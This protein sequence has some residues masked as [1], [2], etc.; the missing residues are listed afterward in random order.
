MCINVG[1]VTMKSLIV[2]T[3]K[4]VNVS[5][6]ELNVC[7]FYSK[8]WK[9]IIY[10]HCMSQS[11]PFR[12]TPPISKTNIAPRHWDLIL[13]FSLTFYHLHLR[14]SEW[15]YEWNYNVPWNLRYLRPKAVTQWLCWLNDKLF[16]RQIIFNVNISDWYTYK[17]EQDTKMTCLH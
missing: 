5:S 2:L 8:F 3:Y 11:Y 17:Y 7:P 6:S 16:R 10:K 1:F 9:R 14:V 4:S 12:S 15:N 13:V